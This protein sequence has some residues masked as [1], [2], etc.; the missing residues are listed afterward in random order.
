MY[1]PTDDGSKDNIFVSA[2]FDP[3]SHFETETI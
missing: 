1:V 3:A 2:S